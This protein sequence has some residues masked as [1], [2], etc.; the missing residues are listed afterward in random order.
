MGFDSETAEG[1]AG[2]TGCEAEKAVQFL[3]DGRSYADVPL[4][5]IDVA[6]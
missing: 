3:M 1:T 6:G 5:P 4:Q 2:A